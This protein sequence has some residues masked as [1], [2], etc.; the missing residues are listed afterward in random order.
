MISDTFPFWLVKLPSLKV[1]VLRNNM[2]YGP[3]KILG[4]TYVLP[5]LLMLDVSSNN[6]TGELSGDFFQSLSAMAMT[7]RNKSA[8]NVIVGEYDR[9]NYQVACKAY[10]EAA[11]QKKKKKP[12]RTQKKEQLLVYS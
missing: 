3:V 9:T 10:E 2:F 11:T 1:L 5:N 6:L 8:K 12:R 7:E 4:R